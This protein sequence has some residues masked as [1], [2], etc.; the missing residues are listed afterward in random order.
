M[1]K[2]VKRLFLW[3]APFTFLVLFYF[4]P[5]TNILGLSLTRDSTGLFSPF[6]EAINSSSVLRV[7]WF[8]I[9]QAGLSTL[10]TFL[11]GL[12]GAFLLARYQFHGKALLRAFTGV[13]FVMPTLVVAAGF[14]AL[15]GPK[16]WINTALMNLFSLDYPP[17]EFVNTLGAILVAHVFYNITI[18]LRLVGD[19]WTRL[20]PRLEQAARIL[21]ANRLEVYRNITLPLLR[22]AILA[23][24]LLIFIFTFTSFGVILVLGGPHYATLEVEIYYQTV[25]LFNLPLAAVLSVL[26]LI[27]TL[28]LTVI[29]TSLMRR[30]SR[31][32]KQRSQSITQS[33]LNS[34]KSRGFAVI[35]FGTILILTTA[36]LIALGTRSLITFQNDHILRGDSTPGLTLEFY[37]QLTINP[38]RSL[39]YAPPSTAIA[40]SLGYAVVTVTMALLIGLPAASDIHPL[41]S[42]FEQLF[43]FAVS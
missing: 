14:N 8:T 35:V 5:L 24:A 31:P 32:L 19:F 23:A 22:P 12:P 38:Q 9:W 7:L 33:K 42:F 43:N 34:W 27:C 37:R 2:A 21:G 4:Y 16:G 41:Q 15:L 36:P 17:V 3:V 29:Y 13:A 30:L 26:Q 10:L 40:I 28:A 25:S 11:I 20:D 6:S 18:V 39:F 1:P